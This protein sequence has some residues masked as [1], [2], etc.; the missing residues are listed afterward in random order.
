M[1]SVQQRIRAFAKL[2]AFLQEYLQCFVDLSKRSTDHTLI[3][4][5]HKSVETALQENPWFIRPH[6]NHA[7]S[8]I[9]QILNE[10]NIAKWLN[11]YDFFLNRES[12]L[13]A[14]VILAGNIPAV[15]F[16]DFLC[17]MMSGASFT[18]KLSSGDIYLIP[19][20]ADVLCA[21]EPG[22]SDRIAFTTEKNINADAVIATGSNNTARYFEYQ[23]GRLPHI[24]R[25][26][27]NAI[28]V[29]SGEESESQLKDL[30]Q[31]V[32]LHFGLGCRNVSKLYLPS[33]FDFDPFLKACQAFDYVATH[34]PFMNNYRYNKAVLSIQGTQFIDRDFL[35]LINADAIS[36]PVAMLHYGYYKNI[37]ELAPHLEMQNDQIQCIVSQP[38]LLPFATLNFGETQ[39]PALDDYADGIDTMEF[40]AKVSRKIK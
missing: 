11:H 4:S 5:F 3:Q 10:K 17:V 9:A 13:K 22:F 15:G 27:R 31:D 40:L 18:G 16:H 38:N 24:F 21:F 2:G 28:A 35:L 36:S 23:Y 39:Q 34:K 8:A 7:L 14:G 25:R 1:P 19:A 26:N 20:L 30:A 32:F 6:L 12:N 33:G 29:L 37:D